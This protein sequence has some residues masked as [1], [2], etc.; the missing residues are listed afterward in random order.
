MYWHCISG[1]TVFPIKIAAKFKIPLIIWGAHQG[2]DQVGMF[3]HTDEVEM[4]RK[5]RKEHDLMNFEAED[6]IDKGGLTES[7][8]EN[9]LYPTD[10]E[11]SEVG[12]RG[13]YLNNYVRWDSKMQHE[14]MIQKYNYKTNIQTRTFDRYNDV[15]SIHYSGIHD[16]IKFIKH[17][18][19]KITDHC[20]REIRL[21]RLSR[22]NAVQL[23]NKY[24]NK[25]IDD[26]NLF[27][28]WIKI[29]KKDFFEI[30]NKFR[31]KNFWYKK[32]VNGS[33]GI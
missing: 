10:K 15:N 28:N 9:Y 31:N 33:L 14:K 19:G 23:I 17:G 21:K 16:Y 1:Y 3:S 18:Y 32:M 6:L 22:E 25:E 5:Y 27:L 26:L 20:T 11:I 13:I 4:T 30:V 2:V 12:I 8:L 24:N 29:S 7:D